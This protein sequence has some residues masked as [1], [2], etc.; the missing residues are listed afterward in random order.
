M[1]YGELA[2]YQKGAQA[3]SPTRSCSRLARAEL[4]FPNLE[5]AASPRRLGR[6]AEVGV[7]DGNIVAITGRDALA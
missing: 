7:P 6:V 4:L 1:S 5:R 3:R 2:L